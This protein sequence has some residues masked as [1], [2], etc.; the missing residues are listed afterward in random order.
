MVRTTHYLPY[1]QSKLLEILAVP[2]QNLASAEKKLISLSSRKIFPTLSTI[3]TL[4][5]VCRD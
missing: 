4:E 3:P 2:A 1:T 5:A